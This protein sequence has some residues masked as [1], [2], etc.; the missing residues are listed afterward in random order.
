[1]AALFCKRATVALWDLRARL[2][3]PAREHDNHRSAI[4]D[5]HA[6]LTRFP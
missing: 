4:D 2:A 1:M 3:A 6:S 5:D